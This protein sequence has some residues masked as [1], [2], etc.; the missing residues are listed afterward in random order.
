MRKQ[1]EITSQNVRPLLTT[2]PNT[3]ANVNAKLTQATILES[4]I[5]IVPLGSRLVASLDCSLGSFADTHR[6]VATVTA[7]GMETPGALT[8]VIDFIKDAHFYH[9]L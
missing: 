5:I 6:Q 9:Q 3:V 4:L 1:T 2:K 7:R 8:V